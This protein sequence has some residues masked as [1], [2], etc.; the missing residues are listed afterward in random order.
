MLIGLC[1][2]KTVYMHFI[3]LSFMIFLGSLVQSQTA[4]N[5][6]SD[7]SSIVTFE[8]AISAGASA[9]FGVSS[10]IFMKLKL[11]KTASILFMALNGFKKCAISSNNFASI[12][13]LKSLSLFF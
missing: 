8:Y 13:L 12:F 9:S 3:F 2:A 4:S 11:A 1:F 6:D 7:S 10:L 5:Y